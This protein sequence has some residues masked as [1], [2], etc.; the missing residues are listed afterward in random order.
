MC[1]ADPD[2]WMNL[3]DNKKGFVC[4]SYTLVYIDG[5]LAVYHHPGP[6]MEDLKSRYKLKNDVDREQKRYLGANVSN[7]NY[8]T[9]L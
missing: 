6:V 5:C 1:V 3:A 2:I 8:H 7:I 9:K 4:G